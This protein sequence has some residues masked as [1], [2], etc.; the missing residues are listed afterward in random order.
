MGQDHHAI[1]YDQARLTDDMMA[2]SSPTRLNTLLLQ[3]FS[4]QVMS[5]TFLQ[6]HIS[7]LSSLCTSSFFKV[8]GSATYRRVLQMTVFIILFFRQ[9]LQAFVSSYFFLVNAFFSPVILDLISFSQDLS[10]VYEAPKV[11]KV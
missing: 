4:D 5:K 10:P 8:H 3:T 1:G 6:S 9:R 11:V 2:L 7:Q